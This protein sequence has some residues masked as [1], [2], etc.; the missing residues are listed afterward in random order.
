MN[1]EGIGNNDWQNSTRR[2]RNYFSS[3]ITTE[4]KKT[5][6]NHLV[7]GVENSLRPAIF[8]CSLETEGGTFTL[9]IRKKERDIDIIKSK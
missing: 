7:F 9:L 6:Y 8:N 4:G 3:L 2:R 5:W 1:A